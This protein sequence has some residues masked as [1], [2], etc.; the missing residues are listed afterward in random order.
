MAICILCGKTPIVAKNVP[1]S[2]HKTT[3][4]LKPN[5]QKINGVKVC[6]RCSRTLKKYQVAG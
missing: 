6:T 1:K 2:V 5:V 3:R 4:V